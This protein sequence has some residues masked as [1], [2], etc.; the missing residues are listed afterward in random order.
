LLHPTFSMRS[1]GEG[2]INVGRTSHSL[3]ELVAYDVPSTDHLP[4]VEDAVGFETVYRNFGPSTGR[5]ELTP[6]GN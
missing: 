6:E 1:K 4:N 5:P 2:C 3:V